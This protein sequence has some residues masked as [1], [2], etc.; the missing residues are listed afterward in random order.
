MTKSEEQ[1]VIKKVIAGDKEAFE[2]LVA[3]NEKNV[4][5]LALKMTGSHE[6]ALDLSQEAF[7]RAYMKLEGFRGESRF[8]VWLYRLTYNLCIDFVRNRS[9][10]QLLPITYR[11]DSGQTQDIEIPDNRENPEERLL[12]SEKSKSISD[13]IDQLSLNH[14]EILIMRE[15]TEMSYEQIAETLSISEGT[16]K[17]RIARARKSLADI[18]INKGTFP[19]NCRQKERKEV[20]ES[21]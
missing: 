7:L 21:D 14:R 9:K 19:D 6:D 18:L 5:N 1:Q 8:S 17:S 12:S 4:F 10:V 2:D 13:A 11:D 20:G 16:V 3:A 15:V